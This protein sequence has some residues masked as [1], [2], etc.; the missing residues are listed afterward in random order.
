MNIPTDDLLEYL[1]YRKEQIL[2]DKDELD[3]P[4][5]RI[6]EIDALYYAVENW[7]ARLPGFVAPSSAIK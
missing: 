5:I 7:G 4:D 1:R 6:K 2:Q 3:R